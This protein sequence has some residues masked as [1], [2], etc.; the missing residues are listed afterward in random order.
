MALLL[1]KGDNLADWR[2]VEEFIAD[3]RDATIKFASLRHP[4]GIAQMLEV[5]EGLLDG[6][7]D[8]N[9]GFA[10]QVDAVV[11]QLRSLPQQ[12]GVR[13]LVGDF[14]ESAYRHYRRFRS[15]PAFFEAANRVLQA[16][17]EMLATAARRD[18]R[19]PLPPFALVVLGPAGRL[20]C[21]RFCRIQLALIWEGDGG[22]GEDQRMAVL[23]AE[24]VAGLR[25][26]GVPLDEAITP[27]HAQWRGTLSHWRQRLEDGIKRNNPLEM[28][29][30][31]RLVDQAVLLDANGLAEAFR[32]L[33][34]EQLQRRQAVANL[35]SRCGALSNGLGMMGG[36]KLERSGPHRG[37]FALL[38]HALVPLAACVAAICLHN[39][40]LEDGTPHRLRELVRHGRLDVDLA[41][42][43]LSAWYLFS[44]HRLNLEL[45]AASGED[46]RDILNLD[47]TQL[48][49]QQQEQLREALETVGSL[50]RHLQVMFGQQA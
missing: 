43:A 26:C 46:C 31:L 13:E 16:L 18:T 25:A 19:D 12:D 35:V 27:L 11:A 37:R 23:G 6:E 33:C 9:R 50:Q 3:Y 44:G 21:T 34:G 42:R 22:P 39:E 17:T 5:V 14:Y 49:H 7:I 4:E 10:E 40:L 8:E 29:E 41:E 24:L 30:L 2:G 20:E 47:L 28:I 15:V 32:G 45:S 48:E 38:D 1:A 36:F